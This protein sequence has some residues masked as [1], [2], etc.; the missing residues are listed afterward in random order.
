MPAAFPRHLPAAQTFGSQLPA[1]HLLTP[2]TL[3]AQTVNAQA[4]RHE[5]WRPELHAQ[6]W[7]G[8]SAEGA[9]QQGQ[10]CSESRQSWTCQ[11]RALL[12]TVY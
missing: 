12:P 10:R 4:P 11:S 9:H 1:V 3:Q 8:G 7:T 5:S 6:A 2:L